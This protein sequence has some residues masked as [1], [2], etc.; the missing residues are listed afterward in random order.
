MSGVS[1]RVSRFGRA[2][3]IGS[4]GL[5]AAAM[6]VG[7]AVVRAAAR[8]HIAHRLGRLRGLPQ[9]VGQLLAAAGSDDHVF[10]GLTE[11]VSDV[12]VEE[13]LGWIRRELGRP[14][15]DVFS[16]IDPRAMAASL[17]QVHRATLRDGRE[18]AVKIQY[19]GIA[20]A[21]DSDLE[22]LG[23][24]A[25]PVQTR[26]APFDL[27]AYRDELRRMLERELDYRQEQE[28]L[29]RFA[30]WR[31]DVPG[32][33]TPDPVRELTTPRLLVMTWIG[34]GPIDTTRL[35][36]ARARETVA[37]ALVRVFLHGCLRWRELH[38]D[39]HAGNVRF[40]R[41]GGH[42]RLGLID[43]GSTCRLT[44]TQ[45]SALTRLLLHGEHVLD[46]NLPELFHDLGFCPERLAPIER[47]LPAVVRAIV[48]PFRERLD[49]PLTTSL[50][51]RLSAALEDDRL[52]FRVA[53]TPSLIWVIRAL[54]GL[55]AMLDLLG[56]SP[57]VPGEL[58]RMEVTDV[59]EPGI[60][61]HPSSP[62]GPRTRHLKVEVKKGGEVRARLSFPAAALAHLDS[63]V[64]EDVCV[65]L[66]ARG[67][68][69]K[70]IGER[71]VAEGA[72]VGVLFALDDGDDAVRVWL[73]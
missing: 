25:R 51:E 53:G 68:D 64:P 16:A 11:K 5:N 1:A 73:E 72:P 2:C 58:R 19:P 39:P 69:V 49:R 28:A 31:A 21:V 15:E 54:H 20:D 55:A 9:K 35:W 12:P 26:R 32:L 46:A 8:K 45:V 52:T 66:A 56:V 4:V 65:R 22:S 59:S 61:Q 70:A 67:V 44:A 57:D 38:A 62:V 7:P 48:A 33:A 27:S 34:G 36:D 47:R 42:V 40:E 18:V 14:F 23:W 60:A 6:R 13:S 41:A 43:F 17:G 71:A 50:G 29:A 30:T 37:T 3:A 63:L 24:L 10:D